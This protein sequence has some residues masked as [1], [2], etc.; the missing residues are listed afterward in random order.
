MYISFAYDLVTLT[1]YMIK[2]V[3]DKIGIIIQNQPFINI[4][5]LPE[6]IKELIHYTKQIMFCSN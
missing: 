5:M 6:I 2:R 1:W 4:K 3:Y